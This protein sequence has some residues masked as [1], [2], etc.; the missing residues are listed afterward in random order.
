MNRDDCRFATPMVTS[1]MGHVSI[2]HFCVFLLLIALFLRVALGLLLCS[3]P[4]L[5]I[6]Y[7]H[8]K[9]P[10]ASF[11]PLYLR[12]LFSPDQ[13]PGYYGGSLRVFAGW[14]VFPM[15]CVSDGLPWMYFIDSLIP[16]ES[17]P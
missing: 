2:S 8:A 3:H 12:L 17:H 6:V 10:I 14:P 16:R 7:Y 15:A 11:C 1:W 4:H 9:Y 5:H 13:G